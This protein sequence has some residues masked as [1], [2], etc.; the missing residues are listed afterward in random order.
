MNEKAITP[1]EQTALAIPTDIGI[2]GIFGSMESFKLA[3]DAANYLSGSTMVPQQYRNNPGN[4]I[5]AMEVANRH[6]ASIFAVMQKLVVVHGTPSFEAQYLIGL[7]NSCGRFSPL[8]YEWKGTE[9]KDD[10][11]CRASATRKADGKL[12]EGQWITVEMAKK[13]GWWSKKDKHGGECSFWQK[14][15]GQMMCYRA[16]AFWQRLHA[17]ELSL[18]MHTTEEVRE[19]IN[20]TP[21][22]IVADSPLEARKAEVAERQ[23]EVPDDMN[24]LDELKFALSEKFGVGKG[25]KWIKEQCALVEW[26][27]ANLDDRQ[28]SALL[29]VLNNQKGDQNGNGGDK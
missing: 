27:P 13:N 23:V 22:T 4:C 15:P 20:V 10:W 7:V 24:P 18:G 11:G 1:A 5:I 25:G 6:N 3:V 16:A 29:D 17:P 8:D 12:L 14:I 28:A 2:G 19:I 26:D 9:M 21:A